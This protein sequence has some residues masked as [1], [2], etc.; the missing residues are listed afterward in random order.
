MSGAIARWRT[1]AH[2]IGEEYAKIKHL[3]KATL[4]LWIISVL[5]MSAIAGWIW[6]YLDQRAEDQ[7]DSCVRGR[8]DFQEIVHRLT[9][10]NPNPD[11]QQVIVLDRVL[12]EFVNDC[13]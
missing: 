7:H 1:K 9:D 10:L 5:V 8:S 2:E 13:P 3:V 6:W 12:A 11:Q 4:P